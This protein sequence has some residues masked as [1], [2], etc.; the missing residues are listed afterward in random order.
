MTA[1]PPAHHRFDSASFALRNQHADTLQRR[2]AFRSAYPW[3]AEGVAVH[4]RVIA[5]A[6]STPKVMTPHAWPH[7]EVMADTR[8]RRE[9]EK[10]EWLMQC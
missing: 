8:Y 4:P 10:R 9:R 3:P 5:Q 2:S 6:A 1:I 7:S